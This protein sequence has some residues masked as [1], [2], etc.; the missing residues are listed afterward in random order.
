MELARKES[1]EVNYWKESSFESPN[2][3]TKRNRHNKRKECEHL[4][5]KIKKHINLIKSKRN[6]LEVGAGQG[7]AS[8]FLKRYYLKNSHFTVTDISKY[9][10]KSL[11]F[12]EKEFDV[13]IDRSFAAKSY[14]I[15]APDKSFDFI[16]CYAA[17]HHFVEHKKTLKELNDYYK[18][19]EKLYI[20]M[21]QLA[22]NSF[23]LCTI[24]LLIDKMIS[25]LRMF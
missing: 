3:F 19:M 7:W 25:L 20:S 11:K 9:A 1:I 4:H 14:K 10:I 23:I 22:L 18:K 2:E 16:F 6:I 15:D 12:W 5:Y 21:N 24:G 17:A 8:C 13:K